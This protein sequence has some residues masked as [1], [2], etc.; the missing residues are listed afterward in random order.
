MTGE[1]ELFAR[2]LAE[3]LGCPN[4]LA[5]KIAA[6]RS[7]EPLAVTLAAIGAPNDVSV[8]I[9]TSSDLRDGADYRRIGALARLQDALSP[10]AARRVVAAIIE[11]PQ[12]GKTASR[13][14]R[15]AP[16]A[17][18]PPR[19]TV[20]LALPGSA[21]AR[22]DRAGGGAQKEASVRI[23]RRARPLGDKL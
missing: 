23:S 9:L 20:D 6:D 7:G 5:E 15:R 14:R 22:G 18:K 21:A 4:S 10:S 19:S 1:A 3:T 13:A 12:E 2:A 8:R 11:N 17:P 16:A